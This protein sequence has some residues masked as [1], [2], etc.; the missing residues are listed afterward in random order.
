LKDFKCTYR[1]CSIAAYFIS[2]IVPI[3]FGSNDVGII[4]L[5]MGWMGV[6][7]LDPFIGLPWIANFLYWINLALPNSKNTF[8]IFLSVI[9]IVCGLFLIGV[10]EIPVDEGGGSYSVIVG[11]GFGIWIASFVLL[12]IDRLKIRK[13][14]LVQKV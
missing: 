4:G 13:Q 10:R 7:I 9:T 8:G 14:S 11:I 3:F 1:N 6:L 2:A 12:L 5:F